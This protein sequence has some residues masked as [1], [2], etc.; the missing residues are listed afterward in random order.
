MH[1]T[2]ASLYYL[3]VAAAARLDDLASPGL[4]NALTSLPPSG[5]GRKVLSSL[6]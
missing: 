6:P 4:M 3:V 5:V 1:W 2:G